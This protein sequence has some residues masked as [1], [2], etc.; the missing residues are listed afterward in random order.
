MA[1]Y[2]PAKETISYFLSHVSKRLDKYIGNYDNILLLVDF[3]YSCKGSNY[4]R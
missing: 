1:G 4:Y 3:N 2:N